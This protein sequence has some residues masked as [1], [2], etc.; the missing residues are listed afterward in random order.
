MAGQNTNNNNHCKSN[1]ASQTS[2]QKTTYIRKIQ[3]GKARHP[4]AHLEH[5]QIQLCGGGMAVCCA[6]SLLVSSKFWV[7]RAGTALLFGVLIYGLCFWIHIG[8]YCVSCDFLLFYRICLVVVG[9]FSTA[10]LD[11]W[12]AWAGPGY[13]VAYRG[14]SSLNLVH[15]SMTNLIEF[16]QD[17]NQE[18]VWSGRTGIH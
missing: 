4:N 7:C 16:Q 1:K 11:L 3:K 9:F 6:L 15:A 18:Q 17:M 5:S 8:C 13:P 10:M 14:R 12:L 2:Q